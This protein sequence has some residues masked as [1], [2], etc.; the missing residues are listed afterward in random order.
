MK[1]IWKILGLIPLLCSL[2]CIAQQ[3]LKFYPEVPVNG[4][5]C[6]LLYKA[7]GTVLEG[8]APVSG[9][10]WYYKD[11]AWDAIDINMSLSDSGWVGKVD[12]P[13]NAVFAAFNF[14]SGK[15]IDNCGKQ[16]YA[17]FIRSDEGR[18]APGSYAAWG[19]LKSKVT[20]GMVPQVIN[21]SAYITDEVALF[22]MNNELK[23]FPAS[24]RDIFYP[25]MMILKHSGAQ[26]ADTIIRREIAFMSNLKDLTEMEWR[27]IS[28]AYRELLHES[29]RADSVDRAIVNKFPGGITA[30]DQAIYSLFRADVSKKISLWKTFQQQF[31][32]KKFENVNTD[33]SN[34]YYEKVFRGIV[35]QEL[36]EHNWNL[37]VLDEYIDVAPFTSLTEFHRLLI[38][39]AIEHDQAN[40]DSAFDY[41]VKLV[42][43]IEAYKYKR[44]G[45][46]S[47][48]YS[49]EQWENEIL[50][51]AAPAFLG[52]ASLLHRK[53]MD[54]DALAWIL[55]VK[56]QPLAEQSKFMDLYA[57]LLE[58]NGKHDDAM[59]VALMA[60]KMNKAAPA[61]IDLLKQDYIK[62]HNNSDGFDAY[63]NSL[64]DSKELNAE[65]EA[66]RQELIHTP[67]PDFQLEKLT[68]GKV[69]LSKLKGKVVVIDFWATWCGP[70]KEALPGMQMAVNRFKDDKDV[71]FLFIATQETKADYKEQI[72]K[73]L[74]AKN[75]NINVLL[76]GKNPA[77]GKLDAAFSKYQSVLK[78]SGIPAKLI[79]DQDGVVRW[80]GIGY[81]GSPS[82]LADEMAFLIKTVKENK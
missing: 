17:I 15:V 10:M 42:K 53:G 69:K 26:R 72:K 64:K 80:K 19:M 20:A 56:D 37:S 6:M 63:F 57:Q 51:F 9:I 1:L 81:H 55:K 73:F 3:N 74:A 50:K 49:P 40:F 7:E 62:K 11:K 4:K 79:I 5:E 22:W 39:N 23:Y 65:L 77:T 45:Q 14:N 52:H 44:V 29:G 61:M 70:C 33:I 24:R 78:F 30:R 38:I 58:A 36:K 71:V 25:A 54:K 31:P 82:A 76:D 28:K 68:G 59:Q 32:L 60:A 13:K 16:P 43:A 2:Q 48:F 66:L 35:Y 75:Y 18:E 12:I 41:S 27:K 46:H 67:A 8:K 47:N 34:S 21:D